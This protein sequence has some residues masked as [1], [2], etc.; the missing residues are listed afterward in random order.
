MIQVLGR[1]LLAYVLDRCKRA[2]LDKIIIIVNPQSNVVRDYF[3]DGSEFGL[4]IEYVGQ[5]HP[6]GI[7]HAVGLTEGIVEPPFAVYLGDEL[8]LGSNHTEFIQGFDETNCN[9]SIGLMWV[10]K[11]E[12]IRRNY[13]VD[14]DMET[15]RI[16]YLVEKP[17]VITNKILGC[18][19]YIFDETVFDA[20]RRTPKSV[21]KE[22]EITDTLNTLVEME[23]DV[24]GFFLGGTYLNVTYPEDIA[25][26]EQMLGSGDK[27]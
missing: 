5:A 19:S 6:E 2:G 18:G 26:A 21:K 23:H 17:T 20:I 25:F 27:S 24:H 9:A 13:S 14:I 1:P 4:S 12:L 10:E 15:H 11:E 22:I 16:R 8:Y 7:G 3:G